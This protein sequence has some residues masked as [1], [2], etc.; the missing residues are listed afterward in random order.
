MI[1]KS[2]KVFKVDC[3]LDTL[4]C[5]LQNNQDWSEKIN[6]NHAKR[7]SLPKAF[8][9][10]HKLFFPPKL[11]MISPGRFC[12]Q[13]RVGI[14]RTVSFSVEESENS[15]EIKAGEP[16]N[17]I[18]EV[19]FVSRSSRVQTALRS[20]LFSLNSATKGRTT[21][22]SEQYLDAFVGY[23]RSIGLPPARK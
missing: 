19:G 21:K 10:L 15:L 5:W 17:N 22:F 16:A 14:L 8:L 9:R 12:I 20:T 11:V 18:A 7:Y 23:I 4:I 13:A 2:D 6:G 1:N 3:D